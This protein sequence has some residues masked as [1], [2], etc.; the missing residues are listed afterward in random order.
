MA[1]ELLDEMDTLPT[2]KDIAA[3]LDDL[4]FAPDAAKELGRAVAMG[5]A[6][7]LVEVEPELVLRHPPHTSRKALRHAANSQQQPVFDFADQA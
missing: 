6:A 1:S 4:G 3:M 5:V 7:A 2:A